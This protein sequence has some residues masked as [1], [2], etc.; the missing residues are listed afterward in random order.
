MAL[1]VGDK[2]AIPEAVAEAYRGSGLAH[3]LAISGLHMSLL[4]GLAFLTVRRGLAMIPA[5]ALRYPIKK[6]AAALA[7]VLTAVY[8]L[9]SGASVPTQR[10]FVMTA[11]ALFA[12]MLDRSPFSFRLLGVA[13]MVVALRDPEAVLGPSF[14]MSFAAVAALITVYQLLR[15]GFPLAEWPA[16]PRWP[17]LYAAGLV[18][19]TV[20]ASCATDPF[21]LYHF[22][23]IAVYSLPANLL[24][25]RFWAFG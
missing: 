11:I 22:G 3:M 17:V 10:A 8:L 1:V 18:I 12:V 13:T 20:V 7:L 6:W 14:Q 9:L 24:A 19:T 25:C 2:G 23:W 5:V 21:A 4:A 16:F 15:H